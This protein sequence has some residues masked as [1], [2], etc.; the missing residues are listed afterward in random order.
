VAA[1]GSSFNPVLSPFAI[2]THIHAH[3]YILLGLAATVHKATARNKEL[4]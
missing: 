1:R 4:I 3:L 2:A